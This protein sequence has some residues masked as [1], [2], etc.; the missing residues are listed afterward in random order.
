MNRPESSNAEIGSLVIG[1]VSLVKLSSL[2]TEFAQAR[3]TFSKIAQS[4]ERIRSLLDQLNIVQ[5]QLAT[6]QFESLQVQKQSLL[7]QQ[8]QNERE[9]QRSLSEQRQ[10]E[11]KSAVFSMKKALIDCAEEKDNLSRL[12]MLEEIEGYRASVNL[13]DNELDSI[14]DKEYANE[15]LSKLQQSLESARVSLSAQDHDDMEALRTAVMEIPKL[16][17]KENEL[18]YALDA[19]SFRTHKPP[20]G[21]LNEREELTKS[22]QELEAD[23]DKE[24]T[25]WQRRK[26]IA[27][28]MIVLLLLILLINNGASAVVGVPDLI[29]LIACGTIALVWRNQHKRVES[30]LDEMIAGARRYERGKKATEDL[31]GCEEELKVATAKVFDI[32]RRHPSLKS[33]VTNKLNI[34]DP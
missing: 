22:R 28:V 10:K 16:G 1:G 33:S 31:K 11:L 23:L 15:V 12:L 13:S 29:L 7:Q 20:E 8:I 2:Q 17:S 34:K 6:A 24:S 27:S 14:P 21:L 5:Q 32:I 9:N 30:M 25:S 4:Q 18:E 3:D 19:Q 26:T